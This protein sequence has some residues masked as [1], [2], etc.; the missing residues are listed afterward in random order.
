VIDFLGAASPHGKALPVFFA[1]FTAAMAAMRVL[2]TWFYERT[3]SIALGPV[4]PHQ[5][6]RLA[7]SFQP[8]GRHG[9]ARSG[10]VR[11]LRRHSLAPRSAAYYP[12]F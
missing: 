2:I 4:N 11:P 3:Q 10:L 9:R 8:T 6:H 5:L 7:R 12:L 1:A